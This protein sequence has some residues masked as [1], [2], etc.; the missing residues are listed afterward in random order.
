MEL[1]PT[2]RKHKPS[3]LCLPDLLEV[4]GQK[5]QHYHLSLLQDWQDAQTKS[6]LNTQEFDLPLCKQWLGLHETAS[7]CMHIKG[8]L[9]SKI[10]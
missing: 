3:Q 5:S 10:P 9:L 6:I 7:S 4:P 8:L 1:L 2:V